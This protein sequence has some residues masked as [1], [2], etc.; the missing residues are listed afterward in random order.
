MESFG[1]RP[2]EPE[3]QECKFGDLVVIPKYNTS[4]FKFPLKTT[5]AEIF[6]FDVHTWVATMNPDVGAGFYFSGWGPLPFVFGPVPSQRYLM[7]RVLQGP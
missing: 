1:A 5:K 7:A 4:L 3:A 2:L 6:D